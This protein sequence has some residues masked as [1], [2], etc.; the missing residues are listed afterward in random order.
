MGCYYFINLISNKKFEN[1]FTCIKLVF[2]PNYVTICYSYNEVNKRKIIR[3]I[4]LF[5]TKRNTI[6][7]NDVAYY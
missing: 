2:H 6:K 5:L 1:S 4:L 7:L 3:K